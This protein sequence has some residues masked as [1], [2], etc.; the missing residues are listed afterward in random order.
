MGTPPFQK[1][2]AGRQGGLKRLIPAEPKIGLST[3]KVPHLA[4]PAANNRI[5]CRQACSLE[6][7]YFMLATPSIGTGRL[8]HMHGMTTRKQGSI[9]GFIPRIMPV[10]L[11]SWR[12]SRCL[13]KIGFGTITTDRLRALRAQLCREPPACPQK[14]AA[15]WMME[16]PSFTNISEMR[17]AGRLRLS[18]PVVAQRRSLTP[19]T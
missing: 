18:I 6:T 16:R 13:S 11:E 17:A 5:W 14:W 12:A 10:R 1:E 2:S 3:I 4:F 9:T 19:E 7:R 8:T 15:F